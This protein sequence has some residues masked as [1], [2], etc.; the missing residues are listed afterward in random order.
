M[1]RFIGTKRIA[2]GLAAVA[3]LLAVFTVLA[4]SDS[5][6]L[7]RSTIAGGAASSSGSGFQL[8]GTV[9]QL[10][11]SPSSGGPFTL[12]SGFWAGLADTTA[13]TDPTSLTSTSH[14]TSTWSNDSTVDVEFSGATDNVGV[15]GYS[16]EWST[17]ATTLPNT[18][19][20]VVQGNDPHSATSPALA[21][22]NSHYF[23]LRT[24]DATGNCTSTLHLGPFFVD[25][26]PPAVIISVTDAEAD[27]ALESATVNFSATDTA[28]GVAS[29]SYSV[30]GSPT[31][32]V[33]GSSTSVVLA[34]GTHTVDVFATDNAGNLSATEN[35]TYKF[36]D[37]CPGVANADQTDTDSDGLGNAC[38]PDDDNDGIG[39]TIDTAP[40]VS[41]S[42]FNDGTTFGSITDR[43]GWS[44][45]IADL[46]SPDGVQASISGAGTMAKIVSC[47]NNVEVQ[48]NAAGETANITCGSITV[49]AV[50][51]NTQIVVRTPPTGTPGK[52]TTVKL[53]TGQ[54][55]TLGSPV[56]ADPDNVGNIQVEILDESG[57]IIATL[58]LAASQSV[59]IQLSDPGE[60]VV[61]I[62]LSA[63]PLL[64]TVH[65]QTLTLEPGESVTVTLR[66]AIDIKPG[67]DPNSINPKSK[68]NV[69]VALLSSS[70]FD[71]QTANR[72]TVKFAGASALDIGQSPR[73][74]NGDGL[75]DV[76]FHFSTQSLSLPAGTTEACLTGF[77]GAGVEF[78]GCD[79]VRLVK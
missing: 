71:A 42:A 9:G 11:A 52:A 47:S 22:G 30:D 31:T 44:V 23:H 69:P 32:T 8:S 24:C 54:T 55:V 2:V 75:L 28:S 58:E 3:A 4:Q 27:N 17:S 73:D 29:I 63:V 39:D 25:T 35:R 50:V 43:G 59:D 15:A 77:T 76:V 45:T 74:V 41:S 34:S 53:N 68:G 36:S 12:Q 66:V 40:L 56:T 5:L 51:A 60:S 7:S 64:V 49:H 19:V 70:T 65:G 6:S 26:T 13:P 67:S 18:S 37:N 1:K 38:D 78:T 72:A 79:S 21:N 10:A 48:L 61:I 20:E 46:G 33:P 57:N 16:I 62:N 14:S